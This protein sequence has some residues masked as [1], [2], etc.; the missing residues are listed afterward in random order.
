[1]VLVVGAVAS[2]TSMARSLYPYSSYSLGLLLS[3]IIV[4]VITYINSSI[5]K[6]LRLPDGIE[7][8]IFL[9]HTS[10]IKNIK[11]ISINTAAFEKS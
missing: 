6:K 4:F 2:L 11:Y 5:L 1:M 9:N 10:G 3:S 8:M 7:S